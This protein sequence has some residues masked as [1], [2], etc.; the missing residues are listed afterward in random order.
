MYYFQ[1]QCS[2]GPKGRVTIRS[3]GLKLSYSGP[4]PADH[5]H[6]W[7]LLLDPACPHTGR[8]DHIC[9]RDALPLGFSQVTTCVSGDLGD[10]PDMFWPERQHSSISWCCAN[11]KQPEQR[12][13]QEHVFYP[14]LHIIHVATCASL[15][16]LQVLKCQVFGMWF[17]FCTVS[18]SL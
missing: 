6:C 12:S 2:T 8:A 11:T 18:T 16:R 4:G 7:A 15:L 5:T 9:C 17:L 13:A 10:L 1:W 3:T 14:L